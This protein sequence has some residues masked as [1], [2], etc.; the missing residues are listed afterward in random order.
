MA[1]ATSTGMDDDDDRAKSDRARQETQDDQ[2]DP[3]N[4][5]TRQGQAG[6]S[7]QRT[8]PGRQP[9]FGR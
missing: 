6:P 7:S 5:Q 2:T 3:P 4:P 9:L 8:A 1:D